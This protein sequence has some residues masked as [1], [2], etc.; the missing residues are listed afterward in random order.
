[1]RTRLEQGLT[2]LN[3]SPTPAAALEQY[4]HLLLAQNQVM[5]LTAITESN[6][7]VDLHMLDSAALLTVADFHGKKV[8]DVGTGAGFPGLVL[9]LLEPT[10]E[11]TLLDSLAKRVNWLTEIS[12]QLGAASVQCIH[13]R[14]EEQ[15]LLDGYRDSYDIAVSRA[16]ADLRI[17]SELC[18]PFVKVG[19]FFLAM[20]SENCQEEVNQAGRAIAKLGGQLRPMAQYQIPNTE[21]SRRVVVVEKIQPTPKAY[22]RRF[23]RMKKAPL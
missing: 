21:I 20:K 17:L 13:G 15:A 11:L 10:I 19:G 8:I 7:V 1:M 16:V 14:A 23:S 4:C 2:A 5:N 6:Q 22:P 12:T 3:L 18:L 9:K